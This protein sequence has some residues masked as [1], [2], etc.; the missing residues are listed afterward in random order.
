MEKFIFINVRVPSRCHEHAHPF[1]PP[2]CSH[3]PRNLSTVRYWPPLYPSFRPHALTM[4]L[5][6]Q[7]NNN[8]F[9][10]SK[11]QTNDD[12]TRPQPCLTVLTPSSRPATVPRIRSSCPILRT[13]G[14]CPLQTEYISDITARKQRNN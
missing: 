8:G 4:A 9:I 13:L 14:P 5:R 12:I 10:Q 3:A 6:Q 11:A 1:L 2:D 7:N